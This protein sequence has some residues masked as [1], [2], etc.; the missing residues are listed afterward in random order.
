MGKH[1]KFENITDVKDVNG[2]TKLFDTIDIQSWSFKNFGYEPDRYGPLLVPI[3]VSKI[4]DDPSLII[5]RKFDSR[6]SW[7][8]EI[9]LNALKS[10]TTDQENTIFE[11]KRK[12]RRDEYFREPFTG[13]TLLSQQ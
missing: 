12:K 8:I 10:E 3:I 4:P 6:D 11:K 7:D 5:S 9:V 13:S 1:L 2:L